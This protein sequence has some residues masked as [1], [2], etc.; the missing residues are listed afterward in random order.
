MQAVSSW[1]RG[2]WVGRC[3]RRV[4]PWSAIRAGMENRRSRSRLGSQRRAGW[5]A[6]ASSCS[7]LHRA[8][9]RL[10]DDR[11]QIPSSLELVPHDLRLLGR[12][13]LV[14]GYL[15]AAHCSRLSAT[16]E[17]GWQ[18]HRRDRDAGGGLAMG[19]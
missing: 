2:A 10:V 13:P 19:R 18:D 9:E 3:R 6:R 5:S 14:L 4:R 12:R 8:G 7:L 15:D 1:A 16:F 17:P 11:S